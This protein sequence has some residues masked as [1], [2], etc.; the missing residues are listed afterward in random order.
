MDT[1]ATKL[2]E[3]AF[4]ETGFVFDPYTGATF[5]VNSTGKAILEALRRGDGREAIVDQLRAHF[6][7]HGAR[8]WG[9]ARGEHRVTHEVPEHD[10][11]VHAEDGHLDDFVG[12]VDHERVERDAARAM[13]GREVAE[14]GID[15]RAVES[16]SRQ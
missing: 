12:Y 9:V 15:E 1:S 6:D 8:R 2:R 4:S 14:H 11:E 5:T 10:D 3:L 13:L 7:V 16:R